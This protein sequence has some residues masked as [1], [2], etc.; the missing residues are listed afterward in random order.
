[1]TEQQTKNRELL[2]N[3]YQSIIER[4][5]ETPENVKQLMTFLRSFH[6]YSFAN[7]LMIYSQRPSARMVKGFQQWKQLNRSVRKGEKSIKI[8]APLIK[9]I[10]DDAGEKKR[11][12]FGFRV[13]S[14]FDVAQTDGEELP[15]VS[16]EITGD[17]AEKLPLLESAVAELGFVIQDEP[18]DDAYGKTDGKTITLKAG[19][20]N[21]DRFSTLVH[22][23]A[24]CMLHFG[25]HRPVKK[26][27]EYEAEMVACL[28]SS[29]VGLEIDGGLNYVRMH[30]HES[31]RVDLVLDSAMKVC[32]YF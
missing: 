20:S 4:L 6:D 3:A 21:A 19:L 14:V 11:V 2:E 32:D 1:M 26:V 18:L 17:P 8:Y 12:V 10:E 16:T 22:E 29:F 30:G 13:V 31:P 25:D 7:Q 5:K 15:K 27:R 28:V 23:L 9:T 24:H